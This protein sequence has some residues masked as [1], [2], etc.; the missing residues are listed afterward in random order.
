MTPEL[1]TQCCC[2]CNTPSGKQLL[3]GLPLPLRTVNAG[4]IHGR[5]V[6]IQV[7][8]ILRGQGMRM[9]THK[10]CGCSVYLTDEGLPRGL[11][12][13]WTQM[14]CVASRWESC[15]AGT[16]PPQNKLTRRCCAQTATVAVAV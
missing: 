4:S 13:R 3:L 8:A 1:W 16:H 7:D 5:L 9:H 2:Y 15:P 10:G 12:S 14:R 11:A 6:A